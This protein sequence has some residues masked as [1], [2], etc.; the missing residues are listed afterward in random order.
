[1]FARIE[2]W[3]RDA[4]TPRGAPP[5]ATATPRNRSTA[6]PPHGAA[7]RPAAAAAPATPAT[8]RRRRPRPPP[9]RPPPAAAAARPRR[10]PCGGEGAGRAARGGR[11]ARSGPRGGRASKRRPS[12]PSAAK[13]R[14]ALGPPVG[15][16]AEH[17]AGRQ[18]VSGVCLCGGGNSLAVGGRLWG[19]VHGRPEVRATGIS[20]EHARPSAWIW[21]MFFALPTQMSGRGAEI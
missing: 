4:P 15:G 20:A 9:R 19:S 5:S 12:A 11:P 13:G 8:C 7:R 21:T 16:R 18:S 10:R 6:A 2:R 14:R 1:M 3:R 17:I